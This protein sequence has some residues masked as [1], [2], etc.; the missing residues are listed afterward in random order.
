MLCMKH[1]YQRLAHAMACRAMSPT[2]HQTHLARLVG[3][4]CKPQNIQHLLDPAKHARS[5]KYTPMIAAVL[6]CDT[7][8]L[9]TG[10]G[11][12]P[13]AN[14]AQNPREQAIATIA[15]EPAQPTYWWPWSVSP[16]RIAALPPDFFG[17]LDGY[18]EGRVEEFERA[19]KPHQVSP[20]G[21][22]AA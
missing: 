6:Q 21:Q 13:T 5:S 7:V 18:I 15:K 3:H 4:G 16:D 20:L 19:N 11:T 10:N 2:D 8:W 9:A 14:D 17:R 1:Y 12:S 22:R